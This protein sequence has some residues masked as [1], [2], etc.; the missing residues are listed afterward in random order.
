MLL[1]FAAGTPFVRRSRRQLF[2]FRRDCF[3]PFFLFAVLKTENG[4]GLTGHSWSGPSP[5]RRNG[6]R[7]LTFVDGKLWNKCRPYERKL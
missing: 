5:K 2:N 4:K 7:S 1:V 3:E 6:L